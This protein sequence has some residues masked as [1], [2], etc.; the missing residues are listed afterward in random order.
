MKEYLTIFSLAG[1]T[2]GVVVFTVVFL[3]DVG[4]TYETYRAWISVLLSFVSLI[5]NAAMSY[6]FVK[7]SRKSAVV[8]DPEAHTKPS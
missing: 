2:L 3:L 4:M 7:K 1:L 5:S 8:R 6:Y